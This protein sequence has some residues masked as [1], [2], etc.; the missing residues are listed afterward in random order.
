MAMNDAIAAGLLLASCGTGMLMYYVRNT[1]YYKTTDDSI[2]K[3][4]F[5]QKVI[6]I[7][8]KDIV[9]LSYNK[10]SQVLLVQTDSG[11]MNCYYNVIGFNFL[12]QTLEEKTGLVAEGW[13][14]R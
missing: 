3:R 12:V 7:Q 9:S 1:I 6:S 13:L 4:N 5:L 10:H 14:T 2:I 8:Y 11:R